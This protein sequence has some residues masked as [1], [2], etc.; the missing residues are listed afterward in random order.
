MATGSNAINATLYERINYSFLRDT[1]PIVGVLRSP[2][3]L[4]VHP[5]VPAKTVAEFIAYAKGNKDK[6]N[7]ASFGSGTSSHLTGE[8]FKLR[9]GLQLTH[10]PYRGSGPMLVDLIS[11]QVQVAFDNLPASIEHIRAG[12]L[13]ALAVCTS[14]P[15]E[16]LP[17]VPTL[18]ETLPGFES[19]AWI[20]LVAPKNTPIDVLARVNTE[21]NAALSD[22]K[23]KSRIAELSGTPT[24]GSPGDF[25]KLITEETEKWGQVIRTA[26][27]KP[28]NSRPPGGYPADTRNREPTRPIV[29]SG[30]FKLLAGEPQDALAAGETIASRYPE[31]RAAM[32]R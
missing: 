18:G 5:S 25:E 29:V 13:R 20:G 21:V 9:T 12:K 7:M 32:I 31:R 15:S 27:I 30:Q 11:G 26:N 6:V 8:L 19:S 10:V 28:T 14:T 24:G 1:V 22:M 16:A 23:I 4:E 3:V 2:F 17:G